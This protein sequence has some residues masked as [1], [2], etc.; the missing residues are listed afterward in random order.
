M[1]K[2]YSWKYLLKDFSKK[3]YDTLCYMGYLT[4]QSRFFISLFNW[5]KILVLMD[6]VLLGIKQDKR[7]FFFL[8]NLL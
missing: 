4:K 7:V 8:Q 5:D 3:L 1:L 6:N 2:F